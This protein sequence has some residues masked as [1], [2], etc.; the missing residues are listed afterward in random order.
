MKIFILFMCLLAVT[1]GKD[2]EG[3][4][5]LFENLEQCVKELP[6]CENLK[7]NPLV[8]VPAWHCALKRV[9][10]VTKDDEVIKK[11]GID[12]CKAVMMDEHLEYCYRV[13]TWCIEKEDEKLGSNFEKTSRKLECIILHG[14]MGMIVKPKEENA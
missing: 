6:K 11:K 4:K 10:V 13:V 5:I 9:G 12:Y 8:S 7:R 2:P 1:Y 14:V 3:V